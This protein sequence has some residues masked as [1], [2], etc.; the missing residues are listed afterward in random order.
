ML[1]DISKEN[2]ERRAVSPQQL[3]VAKASQ[4]K[5]QP[6]KYVAYSINVFNQLTVF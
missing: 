1:N 6:T 2:I 5:I 4:F 3:S